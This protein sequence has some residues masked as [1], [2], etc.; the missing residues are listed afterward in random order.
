MCVRLRKRRSPC[1]TR[2]RACQCKTK[3]MLR[4]GWR[5]CGAKAQ[6]RQDEGLGGLIRYYDRTTNAY[7]DYKSTSHS[8]IRLLI[9]MEQTFIMLILIVQILIVHMLVMYILIRRSGSGC[10]ATQEDCR[11][12]ECKGSSWSLS[13]TRSLLASSIIL[14]ILDVYLVYHVSFRDHP[15]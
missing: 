10:F 15:L 3:A 14:D 2:S 8:V 7:F 12:L 9:L 1:G 13:A 11:V 5:A 4:F 6:S